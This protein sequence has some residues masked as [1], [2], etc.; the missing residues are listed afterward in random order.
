MGKSIQPVTRND[1]H[2]EHGPWSRDQEA[3]GVMAP[4]DVEPRQQ[5]Q[6][7]YHPQR[8]V[9][10]YAQAFQA[11]AEVCGVGQDL[12]TEMLV[13]DRGAAKPA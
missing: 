10:R 7:R 3:Q 4:V 8:H 1:H 11:D 5:V 2:N 9:Q 13:T 6:G 12:A